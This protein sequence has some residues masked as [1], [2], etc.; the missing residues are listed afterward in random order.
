MGGFFG[1]LGLAGDSPHLDCQGVV[2]SLAEL[3][4]TRTRVVPELVALVAECA[5]EQLEHQL[6]HPGKLVVFNG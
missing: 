1:P 5:L 2:E 4:E 3:L 6:T